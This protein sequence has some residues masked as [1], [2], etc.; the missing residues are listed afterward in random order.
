[1]NSLHISVSFNFSFH[2]LLSETI[3]VGLQNNSGQDGE[4]QLAMEGQTDQ[5]CTVPNVGDHQP[6]ILRHLYMSPR[7]WGISDSLEH[8]RRYS[9]H[10]QVNCLIFDFLVDYKLVQLNDNCFKTEGYRSQLIFRLVKRLGK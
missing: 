9:S 10:D 3:R 6:D 1:M 2:N 5:L 8:S 7:D 4:R